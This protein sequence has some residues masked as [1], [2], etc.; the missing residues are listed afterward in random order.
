[1]IITDSDTVRFRVG[2]AAR[3]RATGGPVVLGWIC[4][5]VGI[6]D[7]A[8][9]ITDPTSVTTLGKAVFAVLGVVAITLG[10][11]LAM[12]RT[13]GSGDPSLLGWGSAPGHR[14]A[15]DGGQ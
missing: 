14:P 13:V 11:G 6:A 10:A 9:L 15:G 2:F 4:T 7:L 12:P 1:M 3:W 8:N 5:A